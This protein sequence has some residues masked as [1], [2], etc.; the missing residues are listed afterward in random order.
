L[1]Q[2][3]FTFN[4]FYFFREAKPTLPTNFE[5]DTWAK[6]QSAI[7]AIFL[8]QPA[9]CDL[10]KLYQVCT[11]MFLSPCMISTLV[12]TQCS[13]LSM[14]MWFLLVLVLI[15]LFF[16]RLSMIFVCIRWG[17]ISICV[18]KKSVKHIYLQHYNP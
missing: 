10:E 18:L 11:P 5:E 9:L 2:V 3:C 14:R 4:W 16:F 15:I 6:L 7:K 13:N 17:E 8:K 12:S 1:C